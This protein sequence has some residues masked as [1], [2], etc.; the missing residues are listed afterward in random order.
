[1]ATNYDLN[2]TRGS[3]FDVVLRAKDSAGAGI[4]LTNYTA[5]GFVK[6]RYSDTG[7]LLNLNP[8]PRAGAAGISGYLDVTL[9]G[10]HTKDVPI[11]QGVY[12]IE[13]YSGEYHEKLI[14][15]YA[16]ILPEVTY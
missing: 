11:V 3:Q 12:D 13:I 10:I 5:S 4:D 14:Y 6:Y 2:I 9:S 1:M 16:N 7:V 8:V 15:G